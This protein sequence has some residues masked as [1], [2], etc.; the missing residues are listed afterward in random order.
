MPSSAAPGGGSSNTALG[1]VA[2]LGAGGI[3]LFRARAFSSAAGIDDLGTLTALGHSA[4]MFWAGSCY[5]LSSGGST[6]AASANASFTAQGISLGGRD[7]FGVGGV[8]SGPART[9]GGRVGPPATWLLSTPGSGER[10]AIVALLLA[11]SA[12]FGA[13]FGAL[14][15][16]GRASEADVG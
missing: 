1:L 15:P 11:V 12:L 7:R 13:A 14:V 6:S 8:V 10:T 4:S 3:A 2:L 9:T 5:P 16:R